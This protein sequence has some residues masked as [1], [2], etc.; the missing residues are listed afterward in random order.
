MK[1]CR[2]QQNTTGGGFQPQ[3]STVQKYYET[4]TYREW[5]VKISALCLE[6]R[7][8]LKTFAS[9]LLQQAPR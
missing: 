9:N 6:S 8:F 1:V 4:K 3:T 7:Y 5:T 2:Q